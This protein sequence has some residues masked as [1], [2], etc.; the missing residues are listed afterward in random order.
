MYEDGL[1]FAC[2]AYPTPERPEVY[3][4]WLTVE[5][6]RHIAGLADLTEAE[7]QALGGL[8][9]RLSRVLKAVTGA[10]HIYAFVIG[11]GAPHLHV[12][13]L[14]RYPGTPREYWGVR[15]DEWEGAPHG[16]AE[17]IAGLCEKIRVAL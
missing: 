1:V 10:E 2:H 17:E 6:R 5:T 3:L 14:P 4:G 7:G 13:L 12:H 9:A 16:G 11:H 8:I 15:V